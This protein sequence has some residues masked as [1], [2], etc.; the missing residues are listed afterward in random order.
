M[1]FG[2]G[3]GNGTRTNHAESARELADGSRTRTRFDNAM[4][5]HVWAQLGQTF[6]QSGNGNLFFHGREL[7]SYGPH[8]CAGYILPRAGGDSHSRGLVLINADSYSVSTSGHVSQARSAA[9][10]STV[11]VPELTRLVKA[12][13]RALAHAAG[14]A[15]P[16]PAL[17][18]TGRPCDPAPIDWRTFRRELRPDLA[19]HMASLD[20]FPGEAEAAR[21]FDALGY[22]KPEARA[23]RAAR[24][25]ASAARKLAADK[26]KRKESDALAAARDFALCNP[27]DMAGRVVA[28]ARKA[29][30][31]SGHFVEYRRKEAEAKG[32]EVLRAAKA[33][34]RKGWTR[35]A[36]D[37]MAVYKALRGAL[38]EYDAAELRAARASVWKAR[39]RELRGGLAVYNGTGK[40][41]GAAGYGQA[42]D[43]RG[44]A[45]GAEAARNMAEALAQYAAPAARIMGHNPAELAARLESVAA[46][47]DSRVE[48]ARA[49]EA[50]AALRKE[51]RQFVAGVRAMRGLADATPDSIKEAA[52]AVETAK[53]IAWRFAPATVFNPPR[54]S[55]AP[56][57][58]AYRVAGWTPEIMGETEKALQEAARALDSAIV[59]EKRKAEEAKRAESE[60]L[61]TAAREAWRNGAEAIRDDSGRIISA[62]TCEEG[63][64]MLRAEG[65]ERDGSGV[66]VGGTLVTSQRA[67]APLVHAIRAFRFLKLCRERGQGWRANGKRIRVGHFA[68]DSVDSSGNFVAGCHRIRWAEVARLAEALGVAELAPADTTESREHV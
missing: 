66:I 68:I 63:G 32:R 56:L 27:A 18:M 48:L 44:L 60:R 52:E 31:S 64:A 50:R 39:K 35:I 6:G 19:E 49:A 30:R 36:A 34:R 5:A 29:A 15:E 62:T 21:I 22:D 33:A 10:G 53:H 1:T 20:G 7:Y 11:S 28:D 4:T 26:A 65:V 9:R 57:P 51:A 45:T 61:Q 38:G 13:R 42:S 59:E 41:P 8:Y 24:Y 23:A 54:A 16:R 58:V 37:C 2:Y 14:H 55:L 46:D 43:S 40:A 25:H 3:Y 67:E 47:L 12:I 17:D